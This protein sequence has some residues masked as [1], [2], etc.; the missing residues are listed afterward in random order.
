MV[1]QAK[2]TL[3]AGLRVVASPTVLSLRAL[4]NAMVPGSAGAVDLVLRPDLPVAGTSWAE[5]PTVQIGFP[6]NLKHFLYP[7]PEMGYN[8]A[9]ALAQR[10][11]DALAGVH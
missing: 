1:K 5:L 3:P 9:S 11:M 6:A 8:G 2:A 10:M 7:M 4:V